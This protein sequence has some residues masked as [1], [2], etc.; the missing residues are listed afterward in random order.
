MENGLLDL[1]KKTFAQTNMTPG[2]NEGTAQDIIPWVI[3]LES[4]E[5]STKDCDW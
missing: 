3:L 1:A 4:L 5:D 2:A